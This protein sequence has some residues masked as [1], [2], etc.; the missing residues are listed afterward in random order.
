[1][2]YRKNRIWGMILILI[3]F[4]QVS[5]SFSQNEK[6]H[7]L[8]T[9]VSQIYFGEGLP[10]GICNNMEMN[11]ISIGVKNEQGESI[12][13][14]G[15]ESVK[16][17]SF[18]MPGTYTIELMSEHVAV[19]GHEECKH[20]DHNRTVLIEVLPYSIQFDFDNMK[21]SSEII[22]GKEMENETLAIPVIVNTYSGEVLK[23]Q[24][25]KVATAGVNTTLE[26][27]S[28][29]ENLTLNQG[30]NLVTYKLKGSTS[31]NTYIMFDFYDMNGRVHSFGYATQIK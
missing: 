8:N 2:T 30:E 28:M 29:G 25:L 1:M 13:T 18:S 14:L 16:D 20:S 9:E 15:N 7:S 23:T 26:G 27:K 4:G 10:V 19:S 11:N 3:T 17:F 6:N 22:G 5:K 21:L 24:E 31:R 12:A